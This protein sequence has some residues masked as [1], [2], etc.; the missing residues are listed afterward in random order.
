VNRSGNGDYL[1]DISRLGTPQLVQA[2]H[3]WGKVAAPDFYVIPIFDATGATVAA[4]ELELDAS[5]TSVDVVAIVTYTQPYAHDMLT[6]ATPTMAAQAVQ[7]QRKVG[8]RSGTHPRLVYIVFDPVVRQTGKIVWTS[9]GGSPA[10]PV[11]AVSG[12]DGRDY[13]VGTDGMVHALSE[14]PAVI[15]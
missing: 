8:V 1:S 9:G 2:L 14:L 4:A 5:R 7:A 10:E 3:G 15:S 12:T 11:W 13:V 6:R